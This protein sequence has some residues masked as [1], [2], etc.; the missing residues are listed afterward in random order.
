MGH[1]GL[2]LLLASAVLLTLGVSGALYQRAGRID[3]AKRFPA[4]GRMIDVGGFRMHIDISGEGSPCVVFEAGIAATSLSW[5]LVQPEIA[6]LTR[7]ASY[8]RAGLGW[9]D[10]AAEPRGARQ[11]AQ[12]LHRLLGRSGIKPPM[13]LAAHSYGAL[14]AM[15]Y[16]ARFSGDVAGVVLVDPVT[17][18]E[19]TNPP[20]SRLTI[21]RRG[22]RLSRRGALL[23]RLG[24]VR[25]ALDRLSGGSRAVPK[26]I[27]RASSGRGAGLMERLTGQ[28][29]KL[30]RDVW[31]MIRSHWSD[32]KCFEGM[33][34]YLE[35]LPESAASAPDL[36]VDTPLFVLSSANATPAERADHESLAARSSQ[37]RLEIVPESGHWI[38]LDRPDVV[39]RAIRE[40][41]L[42]CR[43]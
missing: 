1:F 24:L 27:A 5:R 6:N 39:I 4:P 36:P 20:K 22:I 41:V 19:W 25:F 12:E 10:L 21:L 33:A 13:V 32:P 28:I 31:P 30:P 11:E 18:S 17:A 43:S 38:H 35:S 40:M 34:R 29:T 23:A 26:L 2:I 9:S 7:T 42:Q 15:E 16:A 3:D 37:G 8:D 14:V